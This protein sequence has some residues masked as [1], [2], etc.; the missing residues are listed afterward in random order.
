MHILIAS[1]HGGFEL[2]TK[3]SNFLKE[4]GHIV[5]DGGAYSL[6]PEDDYPDYVLVAVKKFQEL[7]KNPEKVRLILL[8]RNGVGVCM[9][10][11]KFKEI[12]CTLSFSPDHARS[13][14]ADDNTNTLALPADYI[15]EQEALEIVQ[16]WLETPF[17]NHSR[18]VRRL[19]KFPEEANS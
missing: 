10:A 18:H 17:S 19:N 7:L 9:L 11:N 16:I 14:R 2:K 13:S 5:E 12:R 8:C 15:N 4:A 6:Q 1:D 3:L